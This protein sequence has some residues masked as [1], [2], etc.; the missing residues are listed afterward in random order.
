MDLSTK[1][2]EWEAAA[3]AAAGAGGGVNSA[4][5]EHTRKMEAATAAESKVAEAE[6]GYVDAKA[7]GRQATEDLITAVRSTADELFAANAAPAAP[8]PPPPPPSDNAG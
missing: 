3:A 8:A 4:K 2:D 5:A 6:I 7:A 1:F